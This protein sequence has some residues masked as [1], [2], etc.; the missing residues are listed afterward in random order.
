MTRKDLTA[1]ID[2]VIGDKGIVRTSVW[3]TK[4]LLNKLVSYLEEYTK[5]AVSNVKI[6]V[7]SSVNTSTN[8]V[9][10]KAVKTYVDNKIDTA[11]S[12][13]S[14]NT[15][16]NKVIKA[17]VDKNNMAV[18]ETD[19]LS[20]IQI[21]KKG[22]YKWNSSFSYED[23]YIYDETNSS[24]FFYA[25][26]EFT[27]PSDHPVKMLL[28]GFEWANGDTPVFLRG[29]KYQIHIVNKIASVVGVK[30][31]LQLSLSDV[32][33]I[34]ADELTFV[35]MADNLEVWFPYSI[36]YRI[37]DGTWNVLSAGQKT[38]AIAAGQTISFRGELRPSY[39]TGVGQFVCTAP[40]FATG[41]CMSLLKYNLLNDDATQFKEGEADYAFSYLFASTPIIGCHPN[42]L[43]ATDMLPHN[44]YRHMFRNC[45]ELIQAPE[46]PAT[47]FR[48]LSSGD[49]TTNLKLAR[50]YWGM[51]ENCDSLKCAPTLP[52][53]QLSYGCYTE[54]FS[55]CSSLISA[56]QLPAINLSEKC[57]TGMFYGCINLRK[58]HTLPAVS[59]TEYCYGETKGMFEG[60][61]SLI[62]APEILA[63]K[64][65]SSSLSRMFYGCS[66]LKRIKLLAQ[67]TGTSVA[68]KWV[69]GV[70]S[71]GTFIKAKGVEI[72]TGTNGIPEG[73]TVEEVEV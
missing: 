59:L 22:Y 61:T 24:D 30:S 52:S 19:D 20:S 53:M 31:G 58:A 68:S 21:S 65:S 57:Y 47:S 62:N 41:N 14:T 46:L 25:V 37:D 49:S 11:M 10:S 9:Q 16:Q 36:E 32:E 28:K 18:I 64:T 40:F 44:C 1:L 7:E 66:S 72:S 35:A 2:K 67:P 8:P 33:H 39:G 56:P 13:T 26:I 71:V 60:C 45:V 69:S 29:T 50:Q 27:T 34:T 43:P 70:S 55:G 63:A 38:P 51:F 48:D 5:I 17:Y 15:V 23:N 73:W 3:W 54:M 4:H 12:D 6:D 42:L